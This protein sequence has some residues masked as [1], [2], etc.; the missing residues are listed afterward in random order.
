VIDADV[1]AV[2]NLLKLLEQNVARIPVFHA[3]ALHRDG[4]A[5]TVDCSRLG[6]RIVLIHHDVPRFIFS[7]EPESGLVLFE[8]YIILCDKIQ[9]EESEKYQNAL[10]ARLQFLGFAHCVFF[11]SMV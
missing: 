7:A 9:W 1:C 8:Y 5:D 10:P 4:T 6:G 11:C 3:D 2:H